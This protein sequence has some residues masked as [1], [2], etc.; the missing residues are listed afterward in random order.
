MKKIT[1]YLRKLAFIVIAALIVWHSGYGMGGRPRNIDA[2]KFGYGTDIIQLVVMLRNPQD[3]NYY[4][5]I[6]GM[7]SVVRRADFTTQTPHI[8]LTYANIPLT[9]RLQAQLGTGTAE[10][11]R[12]ALQAKIF[13]RINAVFADKLKTPILLESFE[14]FMVQG[15]LM[16]PEKWLVA[17]YA[18]PKGDA[19]RALQELF[20]EAQR[21]IKESCDGEVWF[22]F[23]YL[24]PHVSLVKFTNDRISDLFHAAKIGK[25]VPS[26]LIQ[27]QKNWLGVESHVGIDATK[28]P[29]PCRKELGGGKEE[30]ERE[31]YRPVGGGVPADEG[32][33]RQID[34]LKQQLITLRSI[35]PDVSK[36]ERTELNKQIIS[37]ENQIRK[38]EGR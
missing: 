1:V 33:Q 14:G 31:E 32:K 26:F 17:R 34:D 24:T 9:A 2:R 5:D 28:L 13:N 30:E 37:I 22:D 10:E 6:F 18:L 23:N 29:L 21:I 7:E 16:A 27:K 19:G 15:S 4:T 25:S 11:T 38:L 12:A 8:T 20:A 35:I 3:V 36:E